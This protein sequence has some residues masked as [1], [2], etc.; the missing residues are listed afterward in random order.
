MS[1]LWKVFFRLIYALSE[2]EEVRHGFFIVEIRELES[3][4]EYRIKYAYSPTHEY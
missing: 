4:P 2:D 3:F 1:T